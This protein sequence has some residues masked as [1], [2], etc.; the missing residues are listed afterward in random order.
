MGWRLNE[1]QRPDA[2]RGGM[3]Y[4]VSPATFRQERRCVVLVLERLKGERTPKA[5]GHRGKRRV[6]EQFVRGKLIRALEQ[7]SGGY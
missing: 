5:R 4:F 3:H 6:R 2:E 7:S 1:F